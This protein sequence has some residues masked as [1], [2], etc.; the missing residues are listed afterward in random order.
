MS[1]PSAGTYYTVVSG[2]QIRKIARSAYGYDR[3]ADIVKSNADLLNGRGTSLEGLPYIYAGDRL[4]LPETEKQ[5]SEIIPASTDDE[6][7][8]RLDG[9]VFRGWTASN[10][11]RNIN[12]VSDAFT[13]TL[14]YDPDNSDLVEK[15]R[16]Y[17]YKTADLF[18]GGNLYI[19]AQC[20]KW[21]ISKRTSQ[22]MMTV[23]A[24]T[25]AGHTVEC[26]AQQSALELSG[27]RLSQI[28]KEIMAPYGDDLAP[29]FEDGDSDIFPKVRKEMTDTDFSFLSGLAAQKGF[30][31][32]SS[33][34]GGMSF[35]RAAINGLHVFRFIEGDSAI[36]SLS[37][38]YDGTGV[39]SALTAVTESAGTPGPSSSLDNPLV[40][41]Y[42]PLVFSADDL[43]S[44]NLS[45]ALQWRRS[46][47]LAESAPLSITV[48]GWRNQYGQLWQENMIG[49]VL[50]PS[51]AIFTETSYI[52]SGVSLQKD[53][54]QG[55]VA[56]LTMVLPQAY[57]LE[58]PDSFPWEG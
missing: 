20:V 39:F 32:T 48:T 53:E 28:A 36:E 50:A 55:N 4:W 25:K 40:P 3:S 33:D 24:R 5:F 54:N 18:I 26:M 8:I 6:I 10:I 21:A 31:I 16:P 23:D 35:I 19:A 11:T 51:V 38:S 41:I 57:S 56:V 37:T 42:R 1:K 45:S 7:A 17:S 22:T 14:P 30:M 44:G 2:D 12:T 29:I 13:F 9:V 34:T 46:K 27:F 43:E 47:A 49:T 52:V 15:T 58:Y